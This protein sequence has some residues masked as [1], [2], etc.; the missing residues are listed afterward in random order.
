MIA[1]RL[2]RKRYGP[3]LDGAGGRFAEGRWNSVGSLICYC[4]SSPALAIL[5]K[6]VHVPRFA[7][8][9][10]DLTLY[11]ID[12]PDNLPV[13]QLGAELPIN[14]TTSVKLTQSIGDNACREGKTAVLIVPSAIVEMDR[15]ILLIGAHAGIAR[16]RV[17]EEHDVQLDRRLFD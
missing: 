15:N 12:I 7:D 14:W 16:V 4:A 11:K 6:R 13:R 1:W 2:A 9:P 17:R 10:S 5:E 3:A 8:L